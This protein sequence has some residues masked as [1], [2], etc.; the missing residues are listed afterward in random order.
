M[1]KKTK[2]TRKPSSRT[3]RVKRKTMKHEHE[4][5][6]EPTVEEHHFYS[7]IA[8]DGNRMFTES[9]KDDEPVKRE[10]FTLRRLE[11]EIPVAA[12]LIKIHLQRKVPP[13]LN[14]PFP[15]DIG[16]KSVLPNPYDLGLMPPQTKRR[17]KH[18]HSRHHRKDDK[19]NVRLVIQDGDG[20]GGGGDGGDGGNYK[21]PRNLFDLP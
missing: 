18:H 3:R 7:K 21:Q 16:F 14:R 1:V 5:E 6:H 17:H 15:R 4:H 8:V 12:D 13:A 2:R 20:D 10:I 19:E 9:Q 11:K